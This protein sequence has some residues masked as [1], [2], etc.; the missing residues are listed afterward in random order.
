MRRRMYSLRAG[1]CE[2]ASNRPAIGQQ[3]A[4]T[5]QRTVPHI[6]RVIGF[7]AQKVVVDDA[8]VSHRPRFEVFLGGLDGRG[9]QLKSRGKCHVFRQRFD[10]IPTPAP[11]NKRTFFTERLPAAEALQH[12]F[13]VGRGATGIKGPGDRVEHLSEVA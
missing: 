1:S 4:S 7:G 13:E 11:W 9:R 2:S 3:P 5:G 8:R 12:A 10:V 6:V